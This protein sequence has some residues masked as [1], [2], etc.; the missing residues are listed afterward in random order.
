VRAVGRGLEVDVAPAAFAALGQQFQLAVF[1]QVGQD[2]AGRVVDDQGADRHAQV[3]V[4]RAAAIAIGAT[5]GFAV[6]ARC[7]WR[8][9]NRP[10][11]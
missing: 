8:S 9:G 2:F 5:A 6:A 11:Y 1:G 4:I 3:H 10:R 7:I